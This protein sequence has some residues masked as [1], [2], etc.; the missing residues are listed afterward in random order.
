MEADGGCGVSLI[1]D[2]DTDPLTGVGAADTP[3]ALSAIH[4]KGC[5]AALWRRQPSAQFQNWIDSVPP[6]HLPRGRVIVRPDAVFDAA[7][8]MCER[9]GT[10]RGVE[11]DR[12][13]KDVVALADIFV[14]VMDASFVRLRFDVVTDNACRKFHVDSITAR[15]VCTYR[16]TGTQ[17]GVMIKGEAPKRIFTVPTG[18]PI[19]LRGTLWPEQPSTGLVHR[20]PPIEGTGETRLVLVLDAIDDADNV[21]SRPTLH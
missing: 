15:L 13:V 10:P 9:C 12:L 20:S 5:A 11:R 14:D 3:D 21:P 18:A 4:H 19:L 7:S 2:G 6:Q 8:A 1:Q 16:G 17:Y